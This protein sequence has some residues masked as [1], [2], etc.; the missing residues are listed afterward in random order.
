MLMH[1]NAM[2]NLVLCSVHARVNLQMQWGWTLLHT[3]VENGNTA[4]V[5]LMLDHGCDPDVQAEAQDTYVSAK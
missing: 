2:N 5:K 3:A 4:M 1:V